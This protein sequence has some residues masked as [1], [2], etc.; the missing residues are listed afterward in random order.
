MR[1]GCHLPAA[2]IMEDL[3]CQ[4]ASVFKQRQQ[5]KLLLGGP[6]LL[7]LLL[8]PV[9]LPNSTAWKLMKTQN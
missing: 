3:L 9:H 1:Q 7:L 6:L 2:V 4:L 5:V 8:P